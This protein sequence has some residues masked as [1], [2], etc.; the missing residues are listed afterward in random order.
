MHEDAVNYYHELLKDSSLAAASAE[1]LDTGLESSKL[2]FGGRRLSP[3]LRPHFI[4]G[5]DWRQIRRICETV[6]SALQKVKNA[7]VADEAILNELGLTDIERELVQINPG[8]SH[9][10]ANCRLD[11]FLTADAYSFVEL[12]GESPAGVAYADSAT[13]IF[14]SL[15]VFEKFAQKYKA[16]G[17]EGS[18]KML[19]VLLGCYEEFLGRKPDKPPTIGIVDLK[20]LPTQK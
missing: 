10:A 18:S 17:L 4:S 19:S 9:V 1:K 13:A 2:I 11:S 20:G 16:S 6:F 12:N 5:R 15:P 7:A 8:Y 14:Q 3:Y